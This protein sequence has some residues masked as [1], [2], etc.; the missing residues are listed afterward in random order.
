M[1]HV[2]CAD[3]DEVGLLFDEHLLRVR[4]PVGNAVALGGRFRGDG[5]QVAHGGDVHKIGNALISGNVRGVADHTRADDGDFELAF[6]HGVL[7]FSLSLKIL[8]KA[9]TSSLRC[10]RP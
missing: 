2:R 8:K 3:G 9:F 1:R 4:I 5:V 7:S 10:P 6:L